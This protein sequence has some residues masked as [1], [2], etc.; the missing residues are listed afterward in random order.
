M[1][2]KEFAEKVERLC[3]FLLDRVPSSEE[4]EEVIKLKEAAG[5]LQ[6]DSQH[7]NLF[8][9]LSNHIRGLP[10]DKKE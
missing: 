2:V 3:E 8:E 10:E 9:G 6:F 1:K 5:D 4:R 7:D